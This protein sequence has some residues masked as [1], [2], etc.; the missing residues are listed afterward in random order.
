[1]AEKQN[2]TPSPVPKSRT[3]FAGLFPEDMPISGVSRAFEGVAEGIGVQTTPQGRSINFSESPLRKG[4]E[5]VVSDPMGALRGAGQ[6]VSGMLEE[7]MQASSIRPNE[8]VREADG[9]MRQATAGELS[10]TLDP[11][12]GG[13]FAAPLAIRTARE[14]IGALA[15]EPGTAPIFGSAD[16]APARRNAAMELKRQG[17]SDEEVFQKTGVFPADDNKLRFEIDDSE[18]KFT[19]QVTKNDYGHI[20]LEDVSLSNEIKL[21]D[22][23]DH[24]EL[25]KYYPDAKDIPLRDTPLFQFFTEGSFDPETGLMRVKKYTGKKDLEQALSGTESTLLHELQHYVQY[26]HDMNTGGNKGQ[27][28]P[29]GYEELRRY[30]D[31]EKNDY[32]NVLRSAEENPFNYRRLPKDLETVEE[33]EYRKA[34][35][36]I[37]PEIDRFSIEDYNKAKERVD[38]ATD[39]LGENQFNDYVDTLRAKDLLEDIDFRASNN[40]KRLS[41]EVEARVVQ[42]RRGMTA[43]QR[44]AQRPPTSQEFL[45]QEKIKGDPLT[46]KQ[47]EISAEKRKELKALEDVFEQARKTV[48]YDPSTTTKK[49]RDGGIVALGPRPKSRGLEDVIRK[50]RRE[51]LMD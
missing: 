40:Y 4:I 26:K 7:Q 37:D 22:V 41:G 21:G 48:N 31:S 35:G 24:P 49:F 14:G 47:G 51:G 18:A 11:T 50:Y 44:A 33:F 10:A 1:M 46:E 34:M 36:E 29:E 13:T 42:D 45:E 8:M 28:L 2:E 5:S 15:P 32:D 3:N 9:T 43:E 12:L 30:V 23:L 20:V 27:F 6:A 25:Y 17:A 39:V 19:G 38:V 16:R